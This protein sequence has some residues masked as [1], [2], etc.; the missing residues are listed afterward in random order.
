MA[1]GDIYRVGCDC[2]SNNRAWSFG[3]YLMEVDPI[4]TGDGLTVAEACDAKWSTAVRALLSTDSELESWHASKRYLGHNPA[5]RKYVYPG[6]G[7]QSGYALTNDNALYISIRQTYTDAAHNGGF[8]IGGQ[9][10]T[11]Q[12]SSKW[13]DSYM[14][15]PVKTFTDTLDGYVDAVSPAPGK[16][17]MIILSKTIRPIV[18]PFWTTMDVTSAQGNNRVMTQS[19]R[20]QK[21][22]GFS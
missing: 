17:R 16:W 3:F 10:Q 19:R 6:T 18:G 13:S 7:T 11:I 4:D 21:V 12:E 9:S 5:G 15:G 20:R 22:R 1:N 2:S 14:S 8:Y